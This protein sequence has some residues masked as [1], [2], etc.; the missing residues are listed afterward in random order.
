LTPSNT[1][2]VTLLV[3]PDGTFHNWDCAAVTA[4]NA[5]GDAAAFWGN[6]QK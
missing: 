6:Q 3:T 5:T 1:G 4:N 2:Y